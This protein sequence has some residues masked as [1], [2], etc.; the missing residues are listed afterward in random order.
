MSSGFLK[1]PHLQQSVEA[2]DNCEALVVMEQISSKSLLNSKTNNVFVSS[3]ND[4]CVICAVCL[5]QNNT[6]QKM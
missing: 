6:T 1:P 3:L 5:R 4:Q 2:D